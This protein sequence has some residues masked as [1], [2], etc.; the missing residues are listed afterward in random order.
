[1]LEE[2][3]KARDE[4]N[5]EYYI[6]LM[7][8]V[9]NFYLEQARVLIN[10]ARFLDASALF[11]EAEAV[12]YEMKAYLQEILDIL[13]SNGSEDQELKESIEQLKNLVSTNAEFEEAFSY[14]LK[15]QDYKLNRNPGTACDYFKQAHELFETLGSEHNKKV[16]NLY[17]D[18]S[19]AME[20]GSSGLESMM[21]GNFN[22][23]K[24]SF[25]HAQLLFGEVEEELPPL[26]D[27]LE[28]QFLYQVLHQSLPIDINGCEILYCL[29]DAR[30][31]LSHGNYSEAAKQFSVLADL[32]QQNIQNMEGTMISE[33]I[34][35]FSVGDY[36]NFLGYSYLAEGEALR[37]QERWDEALQ[38]YAEVKDI[39]KKGAAAYLKSGHPQGLAN[40]EFFINE[41]SKLSE[42]YVKRCKEDK[43]QKTQIQELKNQ[44][45]TM[46]DS[47]SKSG[48]TVNNVNEVNSIIKQ[49]VEIV[50]KLETNIKESIK[51]D[52]LSGLDGIP[53]PNEKREH[54][55]N[56]ANK[57]IT[58][59]KKGNEFM[60][61]VKVFTDDLK[62]IISNVGDIAKPLM[63]FVKA[64]SLLI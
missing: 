28:D 14:F 30:D 62:N 53:L 4:G 11:I 64:I 37:E 38:R 41:I 52:L 57:L 63:P 3:T 59:N 5:L 33:A 9:E 36:Y 19:K 47:M 40:Q 27:N 23:A 51:A 35:H 31:Q 16:Y 13:S 32:Y 49:N 2:A 26:D 44:I 24:A 12:N 15:G 6:D 17:A 22:A 10:Q 25:Q 45:Q 46:I 29:A 21:L 8:K 20:K 1:M 42:L 58:S 48:F 50:Q 39:W 54:I 18:Y 34:M 7:F 56:E 61:D 43:D 55:R 60:E